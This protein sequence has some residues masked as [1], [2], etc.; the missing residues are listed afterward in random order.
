VTVASDAEPKDPVTI[1]MKR[2][3]TVSGRAFDR[4]GNP[5]AGVLVCVGSRPPASDAPSAG[6]GDG[7]GEGGAAE[8]AWIPDYDRSRRATTDASGRWQVA[9]LPDQPFLA[10]ASKDGYVGDLVP[11][12]GRTTPVDLLLV[13]LRP[14]TL[15]RIAEIDRAVQA[16]YG[17]MTTEGETE[18]LL[19]QLFKLRDER[20]RLYAG[21]R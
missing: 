2:G 12:D 4:E 3:V 17:R 21:E 19:E 1:R 11:I 20:M 5:L 10:H 9:D 18:P 8:E 14:E 15:R 7:A 16:L 6:A 13:K